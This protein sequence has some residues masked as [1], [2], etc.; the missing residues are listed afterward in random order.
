MQ[1]AIFFYAIRYFMTLFGYVLLVS[2][3]KTYKIINLIFFWKILFIFHFVLCRFFFKKYFS[4]IL[5]KV[6]KDIKLNSFLNWSNLFSRFVWVFINIEYFN[7]LL[8]NLQRM[9]W[10]DHAVSI[11]LLN[12]KFS[13]PAKFL[14]TPPSKWNAVN[15]L[16]LFQFICAHKTCSAI[17]K[18]H[19]CDFQEFS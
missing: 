4:H 14:C 7:L 19:T 3:R 9:L 16:K 11:G 15:S 13:F 12:M 5:F 6:K 17:T 2:E 8:L 18:P 1:K 10:A